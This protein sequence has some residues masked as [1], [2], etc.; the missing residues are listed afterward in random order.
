MR[1]TWVAKL[2]LSLMVI[3]LVPW[4]WWSA[5]DSTRTWFLLKDVPIT[6]SKESHY[7]TGLITTN[8]DGLYSINISARYSGFIRANPQSAGTRDLACQIGVNDPQTEPC[9]TPPVWK[10]HWTLAS[11]RSTVEGNSDETVG[12]GYISSTG[13]IEREIGTF[14]T[15]AGHRYKFDLTVLFDNHDARIANPRLMVA[16][17]D[18]H[19][20]SSLFLTGLLRLICAPIAIIGAF[21]FLGS[22]LSQ[23][24]RRKRASV[25]ADSHKLG[26]RG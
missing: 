19:T 4:V 24:A 13:D 11:D 10:F 21:L 7:G 16:V 22:L 8:M 15:K 14:R 2:G 1:M 20:E 26:E 3:A 23:R 6:L 12:E 5:W 18:Y 25:L 9:R 17:A